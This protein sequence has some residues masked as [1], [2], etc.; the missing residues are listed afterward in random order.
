MTF[1]RKTFVGGRQQSRRR[2][3][4]TTHE[5][6]VPVA[7]FTEVDAVNAPAGSV[8][9]GQNVY[10][11]T[12]RLEPRERLAPYADNPFQDE[13]VGS[14]LYS[15][16]DGSKLWVVASK[17][18]VGYLNVDSYTTLTFDSSVSNLPL[19]GG[20]TGDIFGVS[21]YLP[22]RDL[23]VGLFTNG[24][25]PMFSWGGPSDSTAYSTLTGAPICADVTLFDN[26]P[27]A[28]NI[29]T[30]SSTSRRVTRATWP[31]AG[32]PEDWV[33][34][35]SGGEDIVDMRGEGTRIFTS[36]D[37]LILMS[38]E[39][40]WRGRRVGFPFIFRYDAL[41]RRTGAPF[42]RAVIQTEHG[43]FWLG[44]DYNIYQL[45][46]ARRIAR[47]GTPI[48]HTLRTTLKTPDRAFFG[49][50]DDRQQLTFYYSITAETA[51][52]KGMTW[53]IA[54]QKWM[55]QAYPFELSRD[56][57]EL[58]IASSSSSWGGLAGTLSAQNYTF[59]DAVGLD[60]T[61]KTGLL[62]SN[63]TTLYYDGSATSDNGTRVLSQ[64]QF[65]ANFANDPTRIKLV[66]EVRMY[67]KSDTASS[68]TL[69]VSGDAFGT[70][71][72][73]TNISL[74][75]QS[76]TTLVRSNPMVSGV[77]PA[78]RVESEDPGWEINRV[79]VRAKKLGEAL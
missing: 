38:T 13:P 8:V 72:N 26:R 7:G 15:D 69:S 49:Y 45:D 34:E 54:E 12:G 22:R 28:W 71:G 76:N 64:A 41:E 57:S 52:T 56:I 79:V 29:L 2:A 70:V 58:P 44:N 55:P 50:N 10:V 6:F 65:A 60:G 40:I 77:V 9:S 39:E 17:E 25:E 21:V 27:V 3:S 67:V 63:S 75:A 32:D 31:V 42:K 37:E 51:P 53:D 48:Q 4:D 68:L 46:T 78:L 30:L 47:I 36:G 43:I 59:N 24:V 18:T 66:D 16:V 73:E 14:W 35:G 1:T 33:G 5:V 23:N 11:R 62:T 61:S 74:S 19:S 20:P